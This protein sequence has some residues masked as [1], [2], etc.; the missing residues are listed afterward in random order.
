MP[1]VFTSVFYTLCALVP[2]MKPAFLMNSDSWILF[3]F[4][5]YIQPNIMYNT[6]QIWEGQTIH[7]KTN[8]APTLTVSA[9]RS[10]QDNNMTVQKKNGCSHTSSCKSFNQAL[11]LLQRINPPKASLFFIFN[12]TSGQCK[13]RVNQCL[14]LLFF[15][16]FFLSCYP[17]KNENGRPKT[18]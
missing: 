11:I 5:L 6:R 16:S 17:V 1:Q 2:S 4:S 18:T 13:S 8:P 7:T 12:N 3:F 15:N 9:Q 14:M 10:A